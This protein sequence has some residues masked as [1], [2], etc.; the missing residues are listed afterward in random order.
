MPWWILVLAGAAPGAAL[1]ALLD[2]LFRRGDAAQLTIA[3]STIRALSQQSADDDATLKL[4]RAQRVQDMARLE[5]DL[6]GSEA[7]RHKE[8]A[9]VAAV[10][11]R[12]RARLRSLETELA[13]VDSLPAL[14]A[15][16]RLMLA[17][18]DMSVV[19]AGD[20]DPGDRAA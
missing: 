16:L 3:V 8:L 10:N 7:E 2:W 11:A 19:P 15:R 12:L 1:G 4:E 6:R 9:G 18:P 5:E 17:D 20:P 13:H 14:R